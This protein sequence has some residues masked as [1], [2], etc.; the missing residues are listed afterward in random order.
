MIRARILDNWI[1][2]QRFMDN[3]ESVSIHIIAGFTILISTIMV[4]FRF[5]RFL[6]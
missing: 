6:N 2:V 4:A 1:R 5:G 3:G